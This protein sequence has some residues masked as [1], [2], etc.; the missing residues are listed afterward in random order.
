MKNRP[1]RSDA[2][3]GFFRVRLLFHHFL[4]GNHGA[5]DN[6][7]VRVR[8][9]RQV[10]RK[11]IQSAG[12]FAGNADGSDDNAVRV[13]EYD[14]SLAEVT[15]NVVSDDCRFSKRVRNVLVQHDSV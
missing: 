3:T 12:A 2:E 7:S 8:S 11:Y 5:V 6:Q 10:I 4:R 13:A 9:I 1:P 15:G 14:L